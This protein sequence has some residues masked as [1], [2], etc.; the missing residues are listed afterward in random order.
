MQSSWSW[1]ESNFHPDDLVDIS[2]TDPNFI[3]SYTLNDF[4]RDQIYTGRIICFQVIIEYDR[5]A[6]T[7]E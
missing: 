2:Y 7:H 4:S 6:C 5:Y 3:P 1:T